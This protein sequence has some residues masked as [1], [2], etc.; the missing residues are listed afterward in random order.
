MIGGTR[1]QGRQVAITT[2]GPHNVKVTV[3]ERASGT[4][5]LGS[6]SLNKATT[7]HS[8]TQDVVACVWAFLRTPDHM[9]LQQIEVD[10]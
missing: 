8:S 3:N 9:T 1:E 10:L 5:G 2:R 6:A 4:V 7:R